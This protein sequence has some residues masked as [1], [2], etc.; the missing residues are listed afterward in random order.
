[1]DKGICGTG[2]N[3]RRTCGLLLAVIVMSMTAGCLSLGGK[4]TY[5][6]SNQETEARI[7]A[8]EN[9]INALEGRQ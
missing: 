6:S 7:A 1:V 9:R 2:R 4:T 5:V 3:L 8:L